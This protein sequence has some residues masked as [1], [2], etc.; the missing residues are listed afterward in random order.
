MHDFN[1]KII[2]VTGGTG[3]IGAELVRQLLSHQPRQIRIFSRDETKQYDL[4]EDLNFPENLRLFIGDIRDRNRLDLA[5]READIILHA[6]AMKHVP[7]CEYNPFEAV[8]TNIIGSQNVI[9]AALANK[10]SKVIAIS[11]DKA[12]NP[13]NIMGTSKLIMEK[14]F[15][16]VNHFMK[17]TGT[18]F[19]CVRFG[20]VTWARGSVLPIWKKQADKNKS[21]RLTN[22][23]MTRFLMSRPQ[24]AEL[25]LKAATYSQGGEIFIL[26]MPAIRVA[27]LAELF[28]SKYYPDNNISITNH[29][30]RPG[31]KKHEDLFDQSDAVKR[32]FENREMFMIMPQSIEIYNKPYNS[33]E[34]AYRKSG[35]TEA[36]DKELLKYSSKDH[37][38]IERISKII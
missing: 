21:I 20:N 36:D 9:E 4:L 10:V 13:T 17:S 6:A 32:V 33:I 23:E 22:S 30:F 3:S 28:I 5:F 12:V 26:K 29:G 34:S 38:D 15:I 18:D 1:N 19:S 8:Q 37:L 14:L 2:V 35:F 27:D 31:E 7:L 24:A 16:N 11:T 25:V